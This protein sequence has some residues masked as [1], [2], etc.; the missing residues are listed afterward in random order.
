MPYDTSVVFRDVG[1]RFESAPD[2]L[3]AELSVHLP[4]GFTGIVGANGAGKT[5][6][7][8]LA[9]G[10]LVPG[11]G[12]VQSPPHAVYCA[13]R[14]DEAPEGLAALLTA[15][16]SEAH[17]LR[18]RLAIEPGFGERWGSLSHGERKR[19]QIASALW[20]EPALLAIDEPTN[21]IDSEARSLL[22]QA[23]ERFRGV[24]LLVSHDRELLDALCAQCLWVE[25]PG[26]T[27]IPGGYSRSSAQREAERAGA[28][29]EREQARRERDQLRR[30][31]VR[32]R[33]QA[34][35][36]H[37]DRSKRGLA[38]KD[39]DARFRKNLARVS[40]KD[41]RAGRL[42]R[43]LEGRSRRAESRLDAARVEKRHELGIWLPGSR[44]RRSL[45][46]R[47]D[48]GSLPLGG[49]RR[50]RFPAL[51]MRPDERIGATGAN[52]AG[53]T[54]LLRHILENVIPAGSCW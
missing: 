52:G 40:G 2:P 23:L 33:E 4:A 25:P 36:S 43:Q 7:L 28:R 14:T 15:T 11:Q 18:G 26:A 1:F 50:L 51:A 49:G 39:H 6:L 27:L 47:I 46:F 9:T 19:A 5:T 13:Q 48:A 20:R 30:E 45:L 8:R 38:L 44:S 37:R 17:W 12:T 32:R 22:V 24:G 16:D 54:T 21:H 53:K 42:L 3:F 35:R 41:G 10:E 31:V 34:S 29:R